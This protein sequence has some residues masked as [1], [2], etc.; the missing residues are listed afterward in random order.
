MTTAAPAASFPGAGGHA[1]TAVA[2]AADRSAALALSEEAKRGG[3]A[4]RGPLSAIPASPNGHGLLPAVRAASVG[5]SALQL[6][7]AE[8]LPAAERV[9]TEGRSCAVEPA[10]PAAPPPQASPD[11]ED[12]STPGPPSK[13]QRASSMGSRP[14]NKRPAPKGPTRRF[15]DGD[16]VSKRFKVIKFVGEGTFSELSHPHSRFW[17]PA[18]PLGPSRGHGAPVDRR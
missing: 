1:P 4:Q 14:S 2:D 5:S 13:A 12:R 8:A 7:E 9:A 3:A 10:T 18:A 11:G 17:G 16:V 6:R 15:R